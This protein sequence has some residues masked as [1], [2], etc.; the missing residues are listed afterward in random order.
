MNVTLAPLFTPWAQN[1]WFQNSGEKTNKKSHRWEQIILFHMENNWMVLQTRTT[2]LQISD[3]KAVGF[4]HQKELPCCVWGANSALC[5]KISPDKQQ[6]IP[7]LVA[8]SFPTNLSIEREE[9]CLP[10][11][12]I[13]FECRQTSRDLL[14]MPEKAKSEIKLLH[15]L[16]EGG[17]RVL[18]ITIEQE[19]SC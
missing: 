7:K 18:P 3:H 15:N 17:Q 19:M 10:L 11:E 13:H 5:S 12:K 2:A 8:S 9:H 6:I 1:N 16:I 4:P 14:L